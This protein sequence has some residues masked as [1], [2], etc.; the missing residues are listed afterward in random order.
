MRK[1]GRSSAARIATVIGLLAGAVGI[2]ILAV[3]GVD[4]PIPPPGLIILLAAALI[5]AVVRRRW[6]AVVGALAGLSEV[7]GFFASGSAAD[8]LH[9][10][11]LGV[12]AGT[13][14][15]LLG[16]L[17]AL[18]AGVLAAAVPSSVPARSRS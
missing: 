12:L 4:M 18:V 13:W 15:R 7:I 5:V 11:S 3:S 9:S 6:A 10:G 14:I 16:V 17:V 2:V 8:L 1:K